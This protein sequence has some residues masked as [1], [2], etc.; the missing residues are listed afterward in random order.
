MQIHKECFPKSSWKLF[1]AL[2]HFGASHSAILAGGTALALQL[3]HRIS[4]DLD[5]FTTQVVDHERALSTL[6]NKISRLEVASESEGTLIGFADGVKFSLF[7]YEYPFVS[8]L[9][10][11]EGTN[12]AGIPDIAAMKIIAVCQR[13]VKRDFVDL[14]AILQNMPFHK[15]APCMVSRFGSTA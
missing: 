12:L 4:V 14:Y 3:G 15:I 13:G 7:H 9:I 1:H 6:R 11:F 10:P 5:F 2:T 8:P